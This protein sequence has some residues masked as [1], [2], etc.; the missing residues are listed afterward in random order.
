M[1]GR[2]VGAVAVSVLGLVF[3]LPAAA[4]AQKPVCPSAELVTEPGVA[5][6]LPTPTCTN[7][8][9]IT[10]FTVTD[11]PHGTVTTGTSR[12]YVPD[13]GFH[14]LDEFSYTITDAVNGTSDPATVEIIVDND[15]VCTSFSVTVPPNVS[16]VLPN[17]PCSD[18]DGDLISVF[19]VGGAHGTKSISGNNLIYTPATG[20]S[21]PDT[22]SFWA[23]DDFFA[24]EDATLNITVSLKDVQT[25]S[26]STMISTVAGSDVPLTASVMV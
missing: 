16:T 21:G 11:P 17:L 8:T 3:A 6:A 13:P 20:Y 12:M 19:V 23:E 18:A 4:S 15:P 24:S 7:V 10:G 14:G 5:L 9:Q 2:V 22:L 25:G 26:L 1:G